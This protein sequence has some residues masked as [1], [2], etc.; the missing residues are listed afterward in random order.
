[1]LD[2][3]YDRWRLYVECDRRI[4][5]AYPDWN[6]LVE[7][8]ETSSERS[9][10]MSLTFKLLDPRLP[11]FQKWTSAFSKSIAELRG[12]AFPIW[13][14]NSGAEDCL[15]LAYLCWFK[16]DD[17]IEVFLER[18]EGNFLFQPEIT[19]YA[20]SPSILFSYRIYSGVSMSF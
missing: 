15:T 6:A 19:R 13:T 1:M 4:I 10:M 12:G 7:N 17:F 3:L 11:H 18:H 5:Y 2:G 16:L 20:T 14:A 9:L 8:T